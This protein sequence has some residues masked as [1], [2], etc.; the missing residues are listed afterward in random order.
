MIQIKHLAIAMAMATLIISGCIHQTRAP[1]QSL[2]IASVPNLRDIG[3]YQT[4]NGAVVRRGLVFRASQLNPISDVD[5]KKIARLNLIVVYDLRTSQERNNRP[6]ELPPN[7][8]DVWIN[9]MGLEKQSMVGQ[10]EE[11]LA[12]PK[13]ANIVLGN[14]K[15]KAMSIQVYRD[16]IS[17]PSTQQ[18]Y[19]ELFVDLG[20]KDQLPALFHCTAGKD[21]AGWATAALLTLLGVS[22]DKVM[23]DYLRS[24]DYIL[25][26]YKKLIN[27]FVAAGGDRTIPMDILSVNKEYLNAAFNEME[28]KYG[29]IENYFSE[30]LGI[31]VAHQKIL[32][33]I[34]LE[35]K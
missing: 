31:D 29:S 5:M 25:P 2:G 27:K 34:Y 9:V 14:G 4:R 28:E 1:G 16:F 3:G 15:A 26:A 32:K 17:Q 20:K 21:R 13:V 35:K 24:N 8:K 30:A 10:I 11:L 22:R 12:N 23:E 33:A 19:R 18:A 6:D 7:V